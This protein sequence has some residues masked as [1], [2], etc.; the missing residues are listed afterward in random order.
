MQFSSLVVLQSINCYMNNEVL[1]INGYPD[2]TAWMNLKVFP[3]E[4]WQP[5]LQGYIQ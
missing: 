2:A 1:E 4:L 5:E 3:L